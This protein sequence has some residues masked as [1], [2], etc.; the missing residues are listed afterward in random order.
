VVRT[1]LIRIIQPQLCLRQDIPNL[2]KLILK[3]Y[4]RTAGHLRTLVK[5]KKGKKWC[6]PLGMSFE[7][8]CKCCKTLRRNG[9]VAWIEQLLTILL[10]MLIST[11]FSGKLCSFDAHW[12]ASTP[13][14]ACVGTNF[15]TYFSICQ[16]E[17]F[18]L[19][20]TLKSSPTALYGGSWPTSAI[21][22]ATTKLLVDVQ[23]IHTAYH[24]QH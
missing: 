14:F 7:N 22:W 11:I 1:I 9:F 20:N 5:T 6:V 8:I 2:A 4:R 18:F 13:H 10:H 21:A 12:A 23:I 3:R 17:I 15:A 24:N 16:Y 19:L